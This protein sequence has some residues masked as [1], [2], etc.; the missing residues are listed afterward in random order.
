M[1]ET[2][3]V[4]GAGLMGHSI[5]LNIAWS[6]QGVILLGMNEAD[7][8]RAH[9]GIQQKLQMLAEQQLIQQS[10]ITTIQDRIR[11]TISLENA[12]ADSTFVIEA[13]PEQ[14]TLKQSLYEQM[15]LLCSEQTIL[16]SNTSGLSPTS[17]AQNMKHPERMVVVHFW[18]P[19][20]L[21]PLVEIVAGEHTNRETI[22]RSM[23]LMVKIDKKPIEVKKEIPGFVGNRLQYALLREAQ[24]LLEQGVAS[25]ED[26]DAAVT[27]SFGRRLPITGPLMS[28]D[29][30]GLDVFQAI[31][32][33]LFP[34]LAVDKAPLPNMQSLVEQG[35]YGAKT[36]QGYYEWTDTFKQQMNEQREELLIAMLKHDQALSAELK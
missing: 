13:A 4:I 6:G 30:G 19:A 35:H 18:N 3:S 2:L 34:N 31:S 29:L 14:L 16:A 33:Y 17:I 23:A 21:I 36:G 8:A 9:E 11:Y 15:E 7:L 1:K 28:A 10:D 25:K 12:L 20:H 27:H 24:Y 32:S 22:D 26:I 5:A